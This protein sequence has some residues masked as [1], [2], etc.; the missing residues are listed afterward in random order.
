MLYRIK[1]EQ[2]GFTLIELLIGLVITGILASLIAGLTLQLY[3]GNAMSTNRM[4]AVKQVESVIFYISRSTQQAQQV[5]LLNS[6]GGV[7]APVNNI[8]NFNLVTGDKLK[9][10]FSDW[11][12]ATTTTTV[13]TVSTGSMSQVINLGQPSAVA[14]HLTTASGSW[15]SETR[16]LSMNVI[17]T[18]SGYRTATETRTFT[19]IPRPA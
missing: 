8:V 2:K 13:Y 7:I 19:I 11:D 12:T 14:Q 9:I 4:T 15:N 3:S 5:I 17:A 1:R 18:V 6:S 10:V 16:T